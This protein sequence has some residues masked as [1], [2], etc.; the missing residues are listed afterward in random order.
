MLR[1]IGTLNFLNQFA[2]GALTVTLPLYLISRGIDVG[3]IGLVLS[4][5]PLAFLLVRIVS[6]VFADVLGVKKFFIASNIFSTITSVVF[7]VAG[8]PLQF[9]IGRICEGA[10]S[11]FF[12][13]V[14]RTA[15]MARSHARKYLTVMGIVRSFGTALG[16]VGAGLLIAY[17]SFEAVFA[18]LFV[19]GILGVVVALALVNRGATLKKPDWKTMF[20]IRKRQLDFWHVS[21]AVVLVNISFVLLF[22]FLLPVMMDIDMGMS[23]LEIAVMLTAFYVSIGMG[24]LLSVRMKMDERRL[25]FFQAM[26]IPMIIALPVSGPY[27]SAVLMLAGFGFGVC[28]GLNEAM[29]GYLVESGRGVSSRIAMLMAPLNIF[30][31]LALAGAG[32]AL[33]AFGNEAMFVFSAILLGGFVILGKKINSDFDGKKK[34]EIIEYH[35]HRGPVSAQAAK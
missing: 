19:L 6:S 9:G 8:T 33:E 25:L 13:A 23:Y 5:L 3:E 22:T 34:K 21:A 4:L 7:A 35:P 10:S 24:G 32:F 11:A 20:S 15:I 14:D 1:K 27:F 28:F 29:I 31:F 18:L 30:Q 16:L 2:Y 17:L 12:W 26:A